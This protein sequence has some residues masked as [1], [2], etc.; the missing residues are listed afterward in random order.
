MVKN[1][2]I[3]VANRLPFKIEKK[4]KGCELI[5][6]AGGLAT[7]LK[8]LGGIVDGKELLW[9]GCADFNQRIWQ[10]CLADPLISG[11]LIQP[12]FINDKNIEKAYYNGFSNSTIWPLFH[13]F[14]SFAEFKEDDFNAYLTVNKLFVAEIIRV[15]KP[16]DIIWIHDYHLMVLPALLRKE[17]M[18]APTG[19][20]LHIPFPAYE[21][22]RLLPERWRKEL[23]EGML[24]ANLI[25]FQ[26]KEYANHFRQTITQTL[27][28]TDKQGILSYNGNHSVV[29][30]FPISIDYTKFNSAWGLPQVEEG[31]KE[32][33]KKYPNAKL[34]FSVDRLDYTK[35]VL[36]RLNAIE[37]LFEDHPQYLGKVIFLI[38]VVPSRNVIKKYR[39]RKKLIDENVGRL[40]GKYGYIDWQPIIYQYRHLNF[41]QLLTFYTSCHVCLITPLRD[42]M[43][44]VA[45]EFVASRVDQQGVLILS[46]MA[47]AAQELT[48][49]VLVNPNDCEKL[50]ESL[51]FA[52]NMTEEEQ[53]RRMEMMQSLLKINDINYWANSFIKG[54][55]EAWKQNTD[56]QAS[57]LSYE[58]KNEILERYRKA[59]H[60]LILLD[61]D[62]TLNEHVS[63]PGQATPS[64]QVL[65]IIRSICATPKN[66]LCIISGRKMEDL[67]AW[68]GGCNVTLLAEHGCLYKSPG[69]QKW[70]QAGSFDAGWK[71]EIRGILK[72]QIEFFPGTSLEE[73]NYSLVWHYRNA[74]KYVAEK[75]V[76]ELMNKLAAINL[77]EKRFVVQTGSKMVEIK[78]RNADKGI[79]SLKVLCSAN[80]DFVMAIGDDSTDEDMFEALKPSAITIKVGLRKTHARYT[81]LNVN[82]VLSFLEQIKALT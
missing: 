23:L 67:A 2:I 34:V 14:P 78:C 71:E 35:G 32:L 11:M 40:N 58:T 63:D 79:A 68:F 42:G 28:A 70:M 7:A 4:Q 64:Q 36:N 44:L 55:Q 74:G 57:S 17:G 5:E 24:S 53:Q 18:A 62:G 61:Y 20:F 51:I 56:M 15:Y 9:V 80:F 3:I 25:G 59:S 48:L 76:M 72:K 43:N 8:S 47:G 10:D 82:Q 60:R 41:E 52:L 19:F 38:N 22:F 75:Q 69:S 39:Q 31:R 33:G 21:I 45:K 81:M 26:T 46:E 27:G 49:S 30:D 16:G 65:D 54:I 13:Y 12:V 29:A 1:K 77:M 37:K 66:N 73:K 50:M 6:S